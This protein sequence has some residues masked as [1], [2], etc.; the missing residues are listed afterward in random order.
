[1]QAGSLRRFK[2]AGAAPLTHLDPAYIENH[3]LSELAT[4]ETLHCEH[5]D[6]AGFLR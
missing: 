3:S 5:R 1:M 6:R 4:N 2:D